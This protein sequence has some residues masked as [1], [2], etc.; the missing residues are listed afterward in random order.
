MGFSK[1]ISIKEAFAKANPYH[2]SDT[3]QINFAQLTAEMICMS[4][5]LYNF[6]HKEL[7]KKLIHSRDSSTIESPRNT[8]KT[9][10]A[11]H[12]L[13]Q[14]VPTRWDSVLN[15]MERLQEQKQAWITYEAESTLISLS[16][17]QW[18]L[19]SRGTNVLAIF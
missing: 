15:M 4:K 14:D 3:K 12:I 7:F 10:Y 2:T 18:R 13:L 1:S 6:V 16:A 9:E 5:L 19:M 17:H 8:R 11:Q